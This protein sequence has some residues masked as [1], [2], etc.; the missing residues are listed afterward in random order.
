[1]VHNKRSPNNKKCESVHVDGMH[2][3]SCKL[4]VEK[5]FKKVQGVKNVRADIN[6]GNVVIETEQSV[7]LNT[8][9]LN[10]LVNSYGYVVTNSSGSAP[11]RAS[12]KLKNYLLP[13]LLAVL[14]AFLFDYVG[15][16]SSFGIATINSES[17]YPSYFVFGLIAGLSSCA[18]IIGG[19]L[20]GA[21]KKWTELY[22]SSLKP[23]IM[24]LTARTISFFVLGGLLGIVGSAF[25]ISVGL[26]TTLILIVSILMIVIGIQMLNV[27]P[28]RAIPTF[29]KLSHIL[30]RVEHGDNKSVPIVL[31]ALT[32]FMPCGFTL[33]AQA[34]ALTMDSFMQAALSML[35]F[36]LGTLPPLL[37]V[38][39]ASSK[40]YTNKKFANQFSYFAGFLIIFL[41][42][43]SLNAH[44]NL[45]GL[46]SFSDATHA[47]QKKDASQT[48]IIG[49]TQ[50]MQME[51]A[52]FEYQP[53]QFALAVNVPVRW[54]IYNSGALGCANAVYAPG[55]YDEVILLKTG[56]NVVEFT[57][58]EKGNYKISCSMGMV[59]P[60]YVTVN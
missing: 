37:L 34:S 39:T 20:L 5:E 47:L 32:F 57:P 17:S 2:C 46:P 41:G 42:L 54:E 40:L 35:A 24:F 44:L 38:G 28:K 15:K 49:D 10:E 8:K 59:P 12:F 21:S 18:A 7:N 29:P 14:F 52:G 19:M 31:G 26:S 43:I 45:L 33:I 36:A 6:T 9:E 51:A 27:F 3:S 1:M 25:T 56:M 22:G 4:L 13:M 58:K 48:K 50:L 16:R 11:A 55:L 23:Q 60:V 30:H 53:K